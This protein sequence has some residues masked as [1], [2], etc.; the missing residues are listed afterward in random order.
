MAVVNVNTSFS[1]MYVSHLLDGIDQIRLMAN[2]KSLPGDEYK[3]LERP[4]RMHVDM[5]ERGL[6]D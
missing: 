4:N 1:L 2:I 3:H 6:V 5:H